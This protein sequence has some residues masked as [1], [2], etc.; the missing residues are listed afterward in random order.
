MSVREVRLRL[1]QV[2]R[3]GLAR[4][5]RCQYR[6]GLNLFRRHFRP[7]RRDV[8]REAFAIRTRCVCCTSVA[9]TGYEQHGYAHSAYGN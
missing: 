1:S 3:S 6:N 2:N 9:D 4:P 5:A 7:S 8:V